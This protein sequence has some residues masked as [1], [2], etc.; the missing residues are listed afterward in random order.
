LVSGREGAPGYSSGFI[1]IFHEEWVALRKR[2]WL[3]WLMLL[4]MAFALCGGGCGGG[5]GGDDSFDDGG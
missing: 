1:K 4:V 5:G 2:S 3:Y